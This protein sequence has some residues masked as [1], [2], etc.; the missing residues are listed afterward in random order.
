VA[1]PRLLVHDLA[2]AGGPGV[3]YTVSTA[4]RQPSTPEERSGN[5]LAEPIYGFESLFLACNTAC[6]RGINRI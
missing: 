1:S 6:R 3:R 4:K 2:G 5:C